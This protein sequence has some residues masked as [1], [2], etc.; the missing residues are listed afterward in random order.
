MHG[1]SIP[2]ERRADVGWPHL[3]VSIPCRILHDATGDRQQRTMMMDQDAIDVKMTNCFGPDAEHVQLVFED[4]AIQLKANTEYTIQNSIKESGNQE[5]HEVPLVTRHLSLVTTPRGLI[6]LKGKG[7][8]H[9]Y[10][11][12]SAS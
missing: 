7:L 3:T 11:L 6:D 5:S 9:A 12:E 1:R 8:M 4:H 2:A 10:W